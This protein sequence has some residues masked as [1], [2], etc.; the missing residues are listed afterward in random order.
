MV[1][2]S[3]SIATANN[4]R[5]R[6]PPQPQSSSSSSS[7]RHSTEKAKRI[8]RI[9]DGMDS[10]DS[11]GS[12]SEGGN[13]NIGKPFNFSNDEDTDNDD[14]DGHMDECYICDD[15]G[16]ESFMKKS[17]FSHYLFF[18]SNQMQIHC[19]ANRCS[20]QSSFAAMVATKRI[21]PNASRSTSI[22]FQT[23]GI[24]PAVATKNQNQKQ[25]QQ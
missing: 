1:T 13:Y 25:H 4:K 11:D 5:E 10:S 19:F 14:N 8:R 6:Q 15:G 24:V 17:K 18:I 12:S 22:L 23:F 3:E 21:M 20:P 2:A 9:L 16:G 7:S